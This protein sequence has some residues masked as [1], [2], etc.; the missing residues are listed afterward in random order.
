MTWARRRRPHDIWYANDAF[1]RM[2]GCARYSA[3]FVPHSAPAA[4]SSRR[5]SGVAAPSARRSS[6]GVMLQRLRR[7]DA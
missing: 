5:I 1:Y 2:G 4:P 3:V 6:A 7:G